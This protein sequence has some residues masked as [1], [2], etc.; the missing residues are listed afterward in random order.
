MATQSG[1]TTS[2]GI[3]AHGAALPAVYAD[4]IRAGLVGAAT[5][6]LWFFV[7]DALAGRPLYTP[8]VLGT[9]L[10]RG[11][12]GLDAPTQLPIAPDLVIA[13]TAVHTLAFV[14]I[15][16]ATAFLLALAEREPHAGFGVVILFVVFQF[17]FV[18]VCMLAAESVLSALAWPAILVGNLLAAATMGAM[19]RYRHAGL[20]IAP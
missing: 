16:T 1:V 3:P 12:T 14:L 15:G 2:G 18:V 17:G 6:A 5:I 8:T 7:L 9:A 19:L 20:T 10:F 13:F 4:G 11:S